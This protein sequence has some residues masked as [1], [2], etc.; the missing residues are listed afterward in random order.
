MAVLQ[1]CSGKVEEAVKELLH[2]LRSKALLPTT[3]PT[4][5]ED[6]AKSKTGEGTREKEDSYPNTVHV[7]LS[8]GNGAV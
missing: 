7:L 3:S 8:R 2:L 6:L 4:D 1:T 5:S